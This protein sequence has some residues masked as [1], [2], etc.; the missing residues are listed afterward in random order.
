MSKEG[1]RSKPLRKE[2]KKRPQ[3]AVKAS[4]KAPCGYV[5][6]LLCLREMPARD[7]EAPEKTATHEESSPTNFSLLK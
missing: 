3:R 4:E 7:A 5:L 2:S 6:Y 1:S